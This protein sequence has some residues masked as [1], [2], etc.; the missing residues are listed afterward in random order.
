[1]YGSRPFVISGTCKREK[2]DPHAELIKNV[3]AACKKEEAMIGPPLYCVASDG[4]SRRGSALT[5]LTHK[6]P[7]SPSSPIFP[8]LSNLRLMNLFVGD[9]DLTAD[10]D[11]K[12]VVKRL[13]NL[14]LRKMGTLVNGVHI[15]SALLRFHLKENQVSTHRLD[16]PLNPHDRQN[17]PLC[18]SLLKEVWS[19][20]DPSPSDKPSF[21]AA[22]RALQL[23]GTLFRH[24]VVPFIQI[25]VSLHEQLSHLSAAAHLATFQVYTVNGAKNKALQ[26]LTF[27]DIILLVKNAY[28]CVAKTKVSSSNSKFWIILLGTDRLESTFD[29]VR[30]MVGTDKNADIL[31]LGTRLSH[32]SCR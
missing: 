6:R 17:V 23:L 29:L 30:S 15:T 8:L 5:M 25:N 2:A 18:Y 21:V 19:L 12:H 16:Y 13:R 11:Y 4:E 26:S 31:Q 9:F 27:R 22:R 14:L 7:M 10:K 20:P 3:I 1:M 28:F 24:I 32:E